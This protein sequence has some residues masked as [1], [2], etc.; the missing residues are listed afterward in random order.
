MRGL[1]LE[2]CLDLFNPK[3]PKWEPAKKKGKKGESKDVPTESDTKEDVVSFAL[4]ERTTVDV[5]VALVELYESHDEA[6]LDTET[7]KSTFVVT[8]TSTVPAVFGT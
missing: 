4:Y 1:P 3:A 7:F 6:S 8:A 2:E 5:L